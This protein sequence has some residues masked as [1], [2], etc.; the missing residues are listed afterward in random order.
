MLKSQ[1]W[2]TVNGEPLPETPKGVWLIQHRRRIKDLEETVWQDTTFVPIGTAFGGFLGFGFVWAA[3]AV[4]RWGALPLYK[5]VSVG[6]RE[7]K[8]KNGQDRN[9]S[10]TVGD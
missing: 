6:F 4:T 5:W 1:G 8:T 3:Y 2:C 7:D 10:G 9:E